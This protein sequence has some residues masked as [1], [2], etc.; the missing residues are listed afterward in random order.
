MEC[1]SIA[2]RNAGVE[3]IEPGEIAARGDRRLHRPVGAV[4]FELVHSFGRLGTAPGAPKNERRRRYRPS[5]G[6]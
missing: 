2:K 4:L 1:W 6:S 5:G 3:F